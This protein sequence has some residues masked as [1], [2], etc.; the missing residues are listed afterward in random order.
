MSKKLIITAALCGAGTSRKETPHVPITHEEIARDAIECVKAG[1]SVIHLHARDEDGKNTMVTE[2]FSEMVHTVKAALAAE[3][4]DV[5]LNLT[6]SGTPFT[7]EQRIAPIS[8][9]KPEMCSFDPGS[10][11]FG[12]AYVFMNPPEFLEKLGRATLDL[13][14]KPELEIFDGGHIGAVEHYIKKGLIKP[15]C[16]Y[17]FV[18]GVGGGMPGNIDSLA[19]LLPKIQPGSTWSITGIGRDH[20]PAMLAGLSAGCDGLRVGIEDNIYLDKGVLA[21]NRQLVE[22]AVALAKLVGREIATA[23]ETRDILGLTQKP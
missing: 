4:L 19:Y 18:L 5:V 6:S 9:F 11:N 15:P 7:H 8:I 17:Q 3:N 16:H 12:H 10:M 23:A 20:M 21:T 22:R 2:I 13:S 1:A 14:V